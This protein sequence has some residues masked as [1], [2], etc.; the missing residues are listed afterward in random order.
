MATE[1]RE[2]S[3][4]IRAIVVID[5]GAIGGVVQTVDSNP[6]AYTRRRLRGSM[7]KQTLPESCE[8]EE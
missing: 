7:S 6:I 3:A 2:T 4:H 1:R 5:V 8:H